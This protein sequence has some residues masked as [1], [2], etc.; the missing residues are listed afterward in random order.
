VP[1]VCHHF[2]KSF[3]DASFY[4]L[5]TPRASLRPPPPLESGKVL[6]WDR[7]PYFVKI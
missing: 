4:N 7:F 1:T 2:G 5:F 6:P 3:F